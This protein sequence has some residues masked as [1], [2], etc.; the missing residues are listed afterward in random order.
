MKSRFQIAAVML[1]QALVV[2]LTGSD[3]VCAATADLAPL[4]LE[5]ATQEAQ[6]NSPQ[7]LRA[8]AAA[9]EAYWKNVE[10]WSGFLPKVSVSGSHYFTQKFQLLDIQFAGNLAQIQQVFPKTSFQLEGSVTLFDGFPD[11]AIL[12]I[13][14]IRIY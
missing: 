14:E 9:E 4:S 2:F 6:N 11:S 7:S 8:K 5:Q 12:H 13:T 3:P 10:A 1:V